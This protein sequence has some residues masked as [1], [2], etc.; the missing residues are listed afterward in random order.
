MEKDN[1]KKGVPCVQEA[2]TKMRIGADHVNG[3]NK[4]INKKKVPCVQKAIA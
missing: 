4:M 1:N 3:N 2:V